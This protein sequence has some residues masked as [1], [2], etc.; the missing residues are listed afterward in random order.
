MNLLVSL[1]ESLN[2]PGTIESDA[3]NTDMRELEEE[4]ESQRGRDDEHVEYVETIVEE[5]TPHAPN[6][7][8]QAGISCDIIGPNCYRVHAPL[9]IHT[10]TLLV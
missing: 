6:L 2:T 4:L 1:I 7:R 8:R 3:V 9:P 5:I 10:R